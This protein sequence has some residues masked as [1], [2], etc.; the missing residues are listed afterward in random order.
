[1]I[2]FFYENDGRPPVEG[3]DFYHLMWVY[4][5][6]HTPM[7]KYDIELTAPHKSNRVKAASQDGRPLRHY[8]NRW[9]I[10][11][12]FAWLQNFRRLVVRYEYHSSNFLGMVCA[13]CMVILLRHF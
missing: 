11:R 9:Q 5:F 13:G 3:L 2:I 12:L 1:M 8:R 6:G 10:E 4:F 7:D